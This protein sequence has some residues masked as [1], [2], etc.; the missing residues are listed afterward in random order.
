MVLSGF[1]DHCDHFSRDLG[2]LT[3]L[4]LLGWL[5]FVPSVSSA[6][7]Q[8]RLDGVAVFATP[9]VWPWGYETDTGDPAGT[10]SEFVDLIAAVANVPVVNSLR[11]HR[12]AVQELETGEADFITLFESPSADLAGRKVATLVITE[13]L[14]AA[15]ADQGAPQPLEQMDGESVAFIRGTYYG[16]AFENA[17]HVH[18]VPV[19]DLAQG[20]DMLLLGRVDAVIASD[21]ALYHTLRAM[22][23]SPQDFRTDTVVARQRG[24][25]YM[26]RKSP[27]PE[28]YEPI[29]EAVEQLIREGEAERIFALP[30]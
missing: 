8:G 12:R 13:I 11:P 17:G 21:Q 29:R 9:Q 5:M 16:E 15:P 6:E 3:V 4:L 7:G 22:G 18:K 1:S 27:R 14:L 28:L 25:L 23:L 19:N 30:Q 10:I 20:I 24:N 26:S 2:R